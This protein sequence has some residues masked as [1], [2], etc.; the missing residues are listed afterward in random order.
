MPENTIREETYCCGGGAGLGKDE[1]MEMRMRGGFP[2]ANAVR[3]VREK[4]DV[5]RLTCMCA[6]DRAVLSALMEYWV[7]E[8]DVGGIHELVANALVID[9]TKRT[10]DLRGNPLP[11]M[12]NKGEDE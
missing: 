9:G 2:R 1:K 3:H 5:N 12:E 10:T 4:H 11:G 7:P 6:I 8:V